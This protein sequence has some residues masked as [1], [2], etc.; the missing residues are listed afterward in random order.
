MKLINTKTHIVLEVSGEASGGDW[1]KLEEYEKLRK[2][3]TKDSKKAEE[4]E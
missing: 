4:S 1:M 2:P 3:K